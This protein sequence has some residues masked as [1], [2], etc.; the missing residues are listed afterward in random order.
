MRQ[1]KNEPDLPHIYILIISYQ[2]DLLTSTTTTIQAR[3]GNADAQ[4]TLG[5]AYWT[6]LGVEESAASAVAW[7]S[8]AAK[9]K[10]PAAQTSLGVAYMIGKG[11]AKPKPA[12]A[13]KHWKRAA[14]AGDVMA[15]TNLGICYMNGEGG[16]QQDQPLAVGYYYRQAAEKGSA[17]AMNNLGMALNTGLGV[18]KDSVAD[19]IWLISEG[20]LLCTDDDAAAAFEDANAV[21][22]DFN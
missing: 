19:C 15:L 16:V 11:V 12:S 9:Q 13:L 10:H 7:W 20:E 2:Q 14:A 18:E 4:A 8:K 21:M 1:Q 6:G 17:Q 22:G 5:L 3:Q